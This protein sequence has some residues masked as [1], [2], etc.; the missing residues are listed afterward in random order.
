VEQVLAE[1]PNVH[2]HFT[3]KYLSRLNQAKIGRDIIASG[4]VTLAPDLKRQFR[5]HIRRY[6][7]QL[8]TVK[9][10]YF[11][12][13]RRITPELVVTV[14]QKHRNTRELATDSRERRSRMTLSATGGGRE[15]LGTDAA[16]HGP[17]GR[18]MVELR[19]ARVGAGV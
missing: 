17:A 10:T 8:K 9:W 6:N 13:S 18:P 14:H 1:R 11:D 7:K 16:S 15:V 3:P 2:V 12:T 4:V 19:A 5:R